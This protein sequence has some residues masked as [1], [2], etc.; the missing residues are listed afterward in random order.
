M[1]YF[2]TITIY[3]YSYNSREVGITLAKSFLQTFE[4]QLIV[5]T[6]MIYENKIPTFFFSLPTGCYLPNDMLFYKVRAVKEI[7]PKILEKGVNRQALVYNNLVPG[8]KGCYLKFTFNSFGTIESVTYLGNIKV[9]YHSI[10]SLVGLH[11]NYLNEILARYEVKLV[12]DIPEFLSENWAVALFHDGFSKLVLKLK[13]IIQDNEIEKIIQ[14]VVN[15]NLSLDRNTL[16]SMLSNISEST[17]Q[18]IE[19]E[20][21]GFLM[22]N[23]NHLPFYYIPSIK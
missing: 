18:K 3:F 15:S 6:S 21:M 20:L 16:K 23:R 17:Q 5:D 7:N 10:I 14:T 8:S 12:E 2:Y 19:L 4:S 11:E 22:E 9:N 13:S 1:Y